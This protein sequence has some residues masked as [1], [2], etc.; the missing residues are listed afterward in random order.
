MDLPTNVAIGDTGPVWQV[1][2]FEDQTNDYT[3]L[4]GGYSC[5]LAVV[6][7]AISRVVAV[8]T[9]DSKFFVAALTSAETS[10]L[11]RGQIY[12]I[13]M[14][15]ENATLVPPMSKEVKFLIFT[16]NGGVP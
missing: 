11:V 13:R 12:D 14:Q 16:T 10:G 7:T 3:V 6:D 1:G 4:D 15:I 8:K 5:R 2:H 9:D